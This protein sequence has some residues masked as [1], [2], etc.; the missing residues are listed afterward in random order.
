MLTPRARGSP[1]DAPYDSRQR[2]K[3]SF[4]VWCASHSAPSLTNSIHDPRVTGRTDAYRKEASVD[5]VTWLRGRGKQRHGSAVQGNATPWYCQTARDLNDLPA[6]PVGYRRKLVQV[7]R[8]LA[9]PR[10]RVAL[11]R[12]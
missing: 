3:K 5:V 2:P 4:E 6:S 12:R 11:N 9:I 1:R 8:G 10:R 7:A